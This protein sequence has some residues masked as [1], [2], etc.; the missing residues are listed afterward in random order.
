[1]E[2]DMTV[3]LWTSFAITIFGILCNVLVLGSGKTTETKPETRVVSVFV[4]IGFAVWA[5]C[6]LFA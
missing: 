6:L 2:E 3:Y 4:G 1:M 5:G